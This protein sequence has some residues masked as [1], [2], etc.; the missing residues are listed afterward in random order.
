[1]NKLKKFL[2]VSTIVSTFFGMVVTVNPA[3]AAASDGDLI[4]MNGLSSVYY[5]KGGKRYVFPNEQTYFSWYSDWNGVKTIPQDELFGYPLGGN[6][7]IRP[8]TKLVKIT[9]N[10]TVYAVEPGGK[11]RAISSETDAINLYGSE[12]AKKVVDVADSFF[13]N[14]AT[15]S[16]LPAGV[17]PV[18]TVVSPQ[19]SNNLF[20]YDGTNYRQ[21]SNDAAF[22]ANGFSFNYVVPTSKTITAGGT[23]IT[24]AE[25]ALFNVSQG[26]TTGGGAVGGTGLTVAMASDTPASANVP[27]NATSVAY[28]KFNV[29]AA[30][31]GEMTI[32]S[33]TATRSGLGAA[34]DFDNV[35]IYEGMT[36]LTTGRSVNTSTNQ[37]VF[38]GLNYKVPAGTTK[39]LTLVADMDDA[40]SGAGHV[41]AF[42]IVAASDVVTTTGTVSGS[43]PM[44][45]NS[46]SVIGQNVGGITIAKTGSIASPKAGQTGALVAS[47][48]LTAATED[49]SVKNITLYQA[50]TINNLNLT[51]FALKQSG[52]TLATATAIANNK[53]IL[54]LTTPF[55]IAKGDVRT[56]ELYVDVNG[57]AKAA[58]TI[59]IYLDNA[60]DL[61]ATGNT[62]GYG[63]GVTRGDYDG[64]TGTGTD[65]S[66]STIEAGQLTIAFQGPGVTDYAVQAKAAELMRFTITA[67]SNIEIRSTVVVLTGGGTADTNFNDANGDSTTG[68]AKY[69]NVKLVDTTTNAVVAGPQDV[70]ASATTDTMTFSDVWNINAG[71]TRTIK[72]VADIANFTPVSDETIKATL[73]AFA[74]ANVKNLDNNTNVSS[75]VPSGNVAG[76]TMNVKTGSLVVSAAGTPAASSII[77]G[78]QSAVVAGYNF[79]AG[80]GKDITITSVKVDAVG[81]DSC[82]TE[83]DCVLDIK[84]YDGAT[85]IG[86]TKSLSSSAATFTNLAVSV[87]KGTTKTLTLKADLINH[88]TL[89][90]SGDTIRFNITTGS[91]YVTAQD[92]NGNTLTAITGAATGPLMTIQTGG[93]VTW[94]AAGTEVGVTDSRIIAAGSTDVTV[95][96]INFSALNED[97]KLSKVRVKA[98]EV[99]NA[100]VGATREVASISLWDGATKIADAITPTAGIDNATTTW[101][102]ADFNSFLSDFIVP[103]NGTK[104]LTIK[105]S[106]NTIAG[107]A[108][109]GANIAFYVDKGVSLFDGTTTSDNLGNNL[110]FRGVNGSSTVLTGAS[111]IAGTENDVNGSTMYIYK[112]VPT[113]TPVALP[114]T[115]LAGG[116]QTV[117][118]FSVTADAKGAIDWTQFIFTM[119]GSAFGATGAITGARLVDESGNTV[120]AAAACTIGGTLSA[121]TTT[122]TGTITCL[123][124][125]DQNISAG[126]TKTYQLKATIAGAASGSTLSTFIGT[127]TGAWAAQ[128]GH[129]TPEAASSF[130]WSDESGLL[131][132]TI[133]SNNMTFGAHTY[134]T[135]I[136]YNTEWKVKNL[137][138]DSQTLAK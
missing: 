37:V 85:Q 82:A 101:A 100:T 89:D 24:G 31:D 49:V 22:L 111:A 80:T 96:K 48:T 13:T 33:I 39:T 104:T 41:N 10:P 83:A 118:K 122:P 134:G 50:G 125:A 91:T 67:A 38:T 90:G 62:Y 127:P 47:F 25:T 7:T 32:G 58:E 59:D 18:G 35:Y 119:T 74:V 3:S 11:L 84:L 36:R 57:A 130:V 95:A 121:G 28:M 78:A 45:G 135:S 77:N 103:V 88:S 138:T 71:Q 129:A 115:V 68:D 87:P 93:T 112:S 108:R 92:A 109:P 2:A 17:F 102:V 20:Y 51:N 34:G 55:V 66:Y 61:Y 75:I 69:T 64:A 107:G 15:D 137:A 126:T 6:V 110:E 12:W 86:Q 26:A 105:A 98:K 30:A 97:L 29:T 116:E 46:M 94:A 132:G 54:P 21:F 120:I 56:F 52:T 8:G 5:L 124:T 114:T 4:K 19:G 76:N 27:K 1:M 40:G 44:N 42:N 106:F 113:I 53:I 117:S 123:A 16:A 23:Q 72:V 60:S 133:A 81:A 63:V 73:N 14:Y 99:N 136:D 79:R 43:F 128:A 65:D 131:T 9:T 70:D